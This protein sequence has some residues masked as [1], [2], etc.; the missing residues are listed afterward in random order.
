MTFQNKM[1]LYG[2]KNHSEQLFSTKP[3][4][5]SQTEAVICDLIWK[6]YFYMT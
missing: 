4:I 1:K 3:G 5:F 2:M 6:F